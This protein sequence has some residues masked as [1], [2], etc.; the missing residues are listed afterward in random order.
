MINIEKMKKLTQWQPQIDLRE[1]ILRTVT[2]YRDY[3]ANRT[4]EEVEK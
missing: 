2:W 3:F 1:G 4:P